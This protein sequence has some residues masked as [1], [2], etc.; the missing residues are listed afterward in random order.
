MPDDNADAL[1]IIC[2]ILHL[3]NDSIPHSLTPSEVFQIAIAADKFDCAMRLKFHTAKWLHPGN[4]QDILEL[5]R[6]SIAAYIL[7]DAWA[8]GQITFAMISRY[9][10]SYILLADEFGDYVSQKTFCM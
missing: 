10:G 6:L 9:R 5:G 8:F 4:T 7:N 3:R 1:T 2:R